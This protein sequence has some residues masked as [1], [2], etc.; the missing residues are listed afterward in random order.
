MKS[1]VLLWGLANGVMMLTIA[2]TFW[3]GLGIAMAAARVHWSISAL[4]TIVQV[5]GCVALIWA[6][7]RLRRRSGFNRSELRQSDGRFTP[8]ARHIMIWFSWTTAAQAVLIG[9]VV[10]LCVSIQAEQIIWPSIGLVV[11][12][13]FIPLGK[14]F[15]VR[16]Y[17]TTGG[18]GSL[19]SLAT[20]TSGMG[21]YAIPLLG[22]G[23]VV[24]MWGTGIWLLCNTGRIADRAVREP[25]SV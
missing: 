17:Y 9:S 3:F 5:G 4:S 18:I 19:L 14:I 11:S 25:W 1:S 6:A 22:A 15:H 20:C 23:M 8:E 13:H 12:L 2:G 16:A 24:V 10:W 7:V 21:P